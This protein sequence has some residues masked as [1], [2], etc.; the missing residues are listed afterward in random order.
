[1]NNKICLPND[2]MK[3][4]IYEKIKEYFNKE[5]S[6]NLK[7]IKRLYLANSDDPNIFKIPKIYKK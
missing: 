2:E 5:F 1:M 4:V 7:A 3:E 6:F